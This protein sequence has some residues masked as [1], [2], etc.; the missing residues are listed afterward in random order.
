MTH[1]Y[2]H[3]SMLCEHVRTK[4]LTARRNEAAGALT[5][6]VLMLP[7]QANRAAAAAA[8]AD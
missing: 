7:A 8:K 2:A 6:S 3:S 4:A 1:L 5:A